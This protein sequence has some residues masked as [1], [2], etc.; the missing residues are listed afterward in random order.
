MLRSSHSVVH[1]YGIIEKRAAQLQ[2]QLLAFMQENHS[3]K[4]IN[5]IA[6]SM[7][8]LDSRYLLSR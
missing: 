1:R 3:A 5:I 7:G 2:E 8:G 4:K 6:H